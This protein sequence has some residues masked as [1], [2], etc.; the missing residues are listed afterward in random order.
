MH[1]FISRQ[2]SKSRQKTIT[3]WEFNLCRSIFFKAKLAFYMTL[4]G[5]WLHTQKS[6][7]Q[8]NNRKSRKCTFSSST[9]LKRRFFEMKLVNKKWAWPFYWS[10]HWD[11]KCKQIY[12]I[13]SGRSQSSALGQKNGE[14]SI[15]PRCLLWYQF[16]ESGSQGY[17]L[18]SQPPGGRPSRGQVGM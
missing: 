9:T 5:L 2:K 10:N 8:N 13:F 17:Y 18:L 16:G 6:I 11:D 4:S 7:K 14:S 1:E 15:N 3:N 12:L